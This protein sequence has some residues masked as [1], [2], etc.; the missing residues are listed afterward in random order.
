[1]ERPDRPGPSPPSRV[2]RGRAGLRRLEFA[3]QRGALRQPAANPASPPRATFAAGRLART[4][5]PGG[6]L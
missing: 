4:G 6:A 5:S 2:A 1:M 3:A